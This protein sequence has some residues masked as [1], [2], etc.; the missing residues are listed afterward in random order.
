MLVLTRHSGESI[1]INGN[2][3]LKVVEVKGDRVR[4]GI[5]APPHVLVDRQEVHERRMQF[6]DPFVSDQTGEVIC[7]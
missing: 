1:V 7:A 3:R 6:A 2:I 5:D 4:L